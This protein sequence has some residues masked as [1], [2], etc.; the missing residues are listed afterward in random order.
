[1][2]ESLSLNLYDL[3]IREACFPLHLVQIQD[4]KAMLTNICI[5]Y[6]NSLEQKGVTNFSEV[7]ENLVPLS[8]FQDVFG[9]H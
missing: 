3:Q 5:L 2:D 1:M 8:F 9:E 7:N 6:F 4:I